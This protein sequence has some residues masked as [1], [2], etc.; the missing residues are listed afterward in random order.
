VNPD[1]FD[2]LAEGFIDG[3][4]TEDEARELAEAVEASPELRAKLLDATSMA[5]LLARAHGTSKDLAPSVLAA[6]RA[7]ADKDA[8]V[9]NVLDHLGHLPAR[10]RAWPWTLAAAAL[11]VVGLAALLR[12]PTPD[13][14]PA[15]PP[16]TAFKD[17][18]QRDAARP[19]SRTGTSATRRSRRPSRISAGPSS[20]RARTRDRCRRTIW[21]CWRC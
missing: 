12:P 5:G 19:P 20:R 13:P 4:L 14:V 16:T 21:R 9:R 3:S 2:V 8:L 17:W 11:I 1:R 18:D 7:P 6:L 10:R 15:A